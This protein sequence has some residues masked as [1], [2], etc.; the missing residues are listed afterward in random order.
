MQLPLPLQMAIESL[1]SSS[2]LKSLMEAREELTKRYRAPVSAQKMTTDAQRLSYLISRMPATYAAACVALKAVKE[3]T[4][5]HFK[6][7]LDLGSGPGTAMWAACD[8]FP[9]IEAASLI[10]QDHSLIAIGKQ[11]ARSGEKT[12][13][14]ANWQSGDL[15]TLTELISHD[16]VILS[17]SIGELH[18]QRIASLLD[19]CW[20]ATRDVLLI[21]EPGTPAGFERIRLMRE[22]LL[23]KGAYIVAPCPH[24]N[25]CPMTGGDWCHFSARAERSSL[26]R[27]LK[28][29]SLGYEDEK[30]SYIAF[31]KHS[32]S[33]ASS[34]ILRH[35]SQH[36]GHVKLTLCTQEGIQHSTISKKMGVL[37]KQTRKLNW[38]DVFPPQ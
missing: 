10:E 22:H 11:L 38:G 23:A 9:E 34:R 5:L 8:I 26:H 36:G 19:L 21:V 15:E 30:F 27:K 7:L 18:P 31:S 2:S 1:T 6:T 28:E 3:I 33:L 16:L 24:S 37:Y 12:I 20:E 29:A 25:R 13:A 32:F 4:S 14:Q 35:P 17:Y